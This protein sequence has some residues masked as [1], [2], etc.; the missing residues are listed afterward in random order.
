M[1]YKSKSELENNRWMRVAKAVEQIVA[2]DKCDCATARRQFRALKRD[3]PAI[4]RVVHPPSLHMPITVPFRT[5][6]VLPPQVLRSFID[7]LWPTNRPGNPAPPTGATTDLDG[8]MLAYARAALDTG[9]KVK[10]DGAITACCKANRC[11]HRK[12]AAAFGKL[13]PELRRTNRET[14]AALRRK[15]TPS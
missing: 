15:Q 1:A 3:F 4:M 7:R 12:A 2:I 10:R 6:L 11:P 5:Q 14:D 9:N 8:W 13:P